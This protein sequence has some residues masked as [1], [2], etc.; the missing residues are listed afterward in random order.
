VPA[1]HVPHAE[2]RVAPLTAE[3]VPAGQFRQ[4]AAEVA[5]VEVE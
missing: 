5:D 4:V 1:P 3:A 2:S